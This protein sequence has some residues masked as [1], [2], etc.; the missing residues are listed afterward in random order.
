MD[1]LI[2]GGLV[3][4]GNVIAFLVLSKRLKAEYGANVFLNRFK[5]EAGSVI[6]EMNQTTE[7]NIQ[8]LENKIERLIVVRDNAERSL[9]VLEVQ[10][11]RKQQNVSTY[12]HLRPRQADSAVDKVEAKSDKTDEQVENFELQGERGDRHAKPTEAVQTHEERIISGKNN[13]IEQNTKNLSESVRKMQNREQLKAR[14]VSMHRAGLASSMISQSC[15]ISL[16]EV[17]L[18][19]SL[20][21]V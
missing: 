6:T 18:I 1:W 15:G 7:R 21:D 11:E 8:I 12:A 14:V 19:V 4:V 10:S 20:A 5:L 2:F 3:V 13:E 9:K 17:E 16:G